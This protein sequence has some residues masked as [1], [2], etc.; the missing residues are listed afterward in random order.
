M[1]LLIFLVTLPGTG[2]GGVIDIGWDGWRSIPWAA[3][4]VLVTIGLL[5]AF[6]WLRA[7]HELLFGCI[8]I[9]VVLTT[10]AVFASVFAR[11]R[12][13]N[14]AAATFALVAA[15]TVAALILIAHDWSRR[16]LVIAAVIAAAALSLFVVRIGYESLSVPP[17]WERSQIAAQAR[18]DENELEAQQARAGPTRQI[19]HSALDQAI[20]AVTGH[21]VGKSTGTCDTSGPDEITS[22]RAWVVAKHALDVELATYRVAVTGAAADEA[23]LKTVLAQPPEVDDTIPAL[24]A[25]ENGPETLWG[26]VFH[27]AG[28][29]LVPGPLGWVVLGALLLWLLKVN[30]NQLAGPVDVLAG[31]NDKRLVTVFRVAVLR[32]VAEPGAAPGAPSASPVT[33]LLDIAGGPLGAVSKIVQAVLTVAGRRYGYQVSIDV[34][35]DGSTT[36]LARVKSVSGGITLAS[37]TFQDSDD[38]DAVE[39]AGLWTA[40]EILNR[41]SRIPSW[42]AWNA[43]TARALAV[44]ENRDDRTIP[45]TV[46]A[47]ALQ[48]APGS[49]LLLTRLGHRY[50]LAGRR[51][52]AI[53]CYARAVTAHPHYWVARYRL[54]AAVG[55]MRHDPD[56]SAKPASER[57]DDL[58]A[59]EPAIIALRVHVGAELGQLQTD[60]RPDDAAGHFKTL[61]MALFR[62]LASDTR[63]MHRLVSALRRSERDSSW[64]SLIPMSTS[65][66][67]RFHP[68]VTSAH[69]SLGDEQELSKLSKQAAKPGSWWQISYNAACGYASIAT[70]DGGQKAEFAQQAL[71]LLEQT[72]VRPGIHQLSADWVRE[73]SALS[74]LAGSPRFSKFLAQLRPGD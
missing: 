35:T 72:L 40:G 53:G 8:T 21:K 23:A 60:D 20:C 63:Y 57:R 65:P 13:E 62:A 34:T 11:R 39:A 2:A 50:E 45:L 67:H 4:I 5:I 70:T 15:L 31:D 66:A 28:P 73:D 14:D 43:D 10:A 6:W 56:W 24:A 25:I 29:P 49:G 12:V 59:I 74:S 37:N 9:F 16:Q 7:D 36:V 33:T 46:L 55:A 38:E 18:A 3:V 27:S 58:R 54:A 22:N 51:I 68:L 71:S 48:E 61:A 41:S 26:S 17:Q 32:N 30:A 44:A 69:M 52:D 19:D 1:P 47:A 64:P 42:A